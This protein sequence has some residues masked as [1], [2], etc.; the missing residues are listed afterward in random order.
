M[1]AII[2]VTLNS[3]KFIKNCLN[4]IRE[5]TGY[6]NYKVVVSDNG[7]TDG[8]IELVKNKYKWVDLIE[9]GKNL[10][11]AGGN[12]IAMKY[13]LKKYNP[14]YF[15]WLNDDI[16]IIQKDWLNEVVKTAESDDKIGIVGTNPIYPD[17]VAQNPGG[18]IKGPFII[19]DKKLDRFKEVDHVTAFCLIKRK[20]IDK[21]GLIDEV[22]IPYL[23][24]ETD[25]C[26]RAKRAGFKIISRGDIRIV[27]YKS[28]TIN[29]EKEVKINSVRFKNDSIF[30]L[31]NLKPHF[32]LIRLFIYLPSVML[33]KKKDEKKTV[34]ISNAK[35]R[36]NLS[37]NTLNMIKGYFYILTH[38]GFIYKKRIERN[39]NS[40]IWY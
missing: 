25:Y 38:I 11:F 23:L 40:K 33:L 32:A 34:S 20:V 27:H 3:G 26:L 7:S 35:L 4:S 37:L 16:K 6:K 15:F 29:R 21:I 19:I 17:G 1:V 39:R 10:Y 2:I 12:N 14:D 22:F 18:Y 28:Q 5:K 24:E 31:I 30:S 8:T 9:N 36:D 13:A